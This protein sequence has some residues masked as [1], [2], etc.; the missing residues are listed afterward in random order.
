MDDW[1]NPGRR[2]QLDQ[3]RLVATARVDARTGDGDPLERFSDATELRRRL[4]T[5]DGAR[6]GGHGRRC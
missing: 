2:R 1:F 5:S 4:G 3:E 6:P